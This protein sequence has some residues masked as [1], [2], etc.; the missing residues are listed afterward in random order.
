MSRAEPEGF[1]ARCHSG[2]WPKGQEEKEGERQGKVAQA[3][4]T[5]IEER[6]GKV[7]QAPRRHV[8]GQEEKEGE[9][10]GT[11]APAPRRN[12]NG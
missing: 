1:R 11:V 3:P 6:Q 4:K 10:Q 5:N 2:G 7:A 12:V 8:K 9:T